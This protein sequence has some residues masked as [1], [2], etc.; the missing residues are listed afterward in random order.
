MPGAAYISLIFNA[1]NT[2][3]GYF[4]VISLETDIFFT[5]AK[6]YDTRPHTHSGWMVNMAV[7]PLLPKEGIA[8]V[9]A[10]IRIARAH[11]MSR[12]MA[13]PTTY[14]WFYQ[15]VRNKGAVGLQARTPGVSKFWELQLWFGWLCCRDTLRNAT[16][17]CWMGAGKS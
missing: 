14:L 3:V 12:N 8:L 6:V 10:N 2:L 1:I 9:L 7:I 15:K 13:I 16:D 5:I 17:G 4:S 11:G